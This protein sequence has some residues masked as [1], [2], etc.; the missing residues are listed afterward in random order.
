MRWNGSAG[1]IAFPVYRTDREDR[2]RYRVS[3]LH[4]TAW[5]IGIGHVDPGSSG[6]AAKGVGSP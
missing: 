4:I 5:T 6:I 2:A 3:R 1:I